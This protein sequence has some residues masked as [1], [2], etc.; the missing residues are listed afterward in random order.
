[1]F[2]TLFAQALDS[3]ENTDPSTLFAQVDPAEAIPPS[4]SADM[5]A[6][7]AKMLLTFAVLILLLFGTYWFIRRLIRFRLQKGVG[8]HSIQVLEKKMISTKTML[9][10]VE[11][12][13]KKVL[14][15]E[16]HLEIKRIE[17]FPNAPE[18]EAKL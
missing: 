16:S 14:L 7:F 10:L 17:S 18:E 12:E 9:Y 4:T 15:A 3:L 2:I 8:A 11:V 6:T 5:G 1:M 13:N